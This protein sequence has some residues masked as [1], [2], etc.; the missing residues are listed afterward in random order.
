MCRTIKPSQ[1]T[2]ALRDA[3]G[4]FATGVAI[5]TASGE[6]STPVGMTINSFS[7]VSMTP[8]LVAWCVDR[9][10]ASYPVFARTPH[11][12]ISVLNDD[13]AELATRFASRGEDKF[14]DM[15]C[16][17]SAPVIEGACA[18]FRCDTYQ[19]F[20][21]GD[22]LMLI[23]RVIEFDKLARTPLLFARGRFH[24]LPVADAADIAA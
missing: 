4:Q 13:Q 2:R 12:C 15:T 19:R 21:L 8:P 1:E 10:A 7:S 22:H 17:G 9:R 5:V 16:N 23:G 20:L 14:R 24:T 6:D 18:Y 3:L 11:F